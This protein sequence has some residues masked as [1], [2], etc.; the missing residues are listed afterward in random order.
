MKW[1]IEAMQDSDWPAEYLSNR[2]A[3]M[4]EMGRRTPGVA[5]RR[6]A[7]L[8][9]VSQRACYS[10]VTQVPI[11]VAA[12]YRSQGPGWRLLS[13]LVPESEA[14]GIWSL[15]AGIFPEN[16]AST[17]LRER[18]GFRPVGIRERIGQR[19]GRWRDTVLVERRSPKVGI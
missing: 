2:R 19:E 4:A 7:V 11:Y 13:T 16:R 1:Q 17:I 14:S 18:E 6:G 12:T 3:G 10:S 8:N 15:Q 5:R 9:P